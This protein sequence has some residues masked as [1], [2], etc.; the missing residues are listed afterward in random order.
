[1][2]VSKICLVGL[3]VMVTFNKNIFCKNPY[4]TI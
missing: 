4:V 3:N 2:C 1:M